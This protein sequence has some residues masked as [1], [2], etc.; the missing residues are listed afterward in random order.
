[1]I[2]SHKLRDGACKT[3]QGACPNFRSVVCGYSLCQ[4]SSMLPEINLRGQWVLAVLVWLRSCFKVCPSWQA[5]T[6]QFITDFNPRQIISIFSSKVHV[7][8]L[9]VCLNFDFFSPASPGGKAVA[10]WKLVLASIQQRKIH[11]FVPVIC[12]LAHDSPLLRKMTVFLSHSPC[13]PAST[14]D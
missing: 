13:K 12:G 5:P 9:Q 2:S 14:T 11:R 10:L 4:Q 1:M 8:F 6:P 7:H 3:S